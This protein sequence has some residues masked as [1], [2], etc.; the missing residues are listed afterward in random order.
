MKKNPLFLPELL[1]SSLPIFKAGNVVKMWVERRTCSSG[2]GEKGRTLRV[3]ER[4]STGKY[5]MLGVQ[6]HNFRNLCQQC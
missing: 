2:R 5:E 3:G 4:F 6:Q 1:F